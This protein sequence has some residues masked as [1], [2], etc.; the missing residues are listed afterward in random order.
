M[1]HRI[2]SIILLTLI[3]GL[4]V[5]SPVLAYIYRATYTV[6]ENASVPYDMVGVQTDNA[7]A[8]QWMADNG[9]FNSTANDTRIETLGGLEKPHMVTENLTYTAIPVPANSQTNLYFTTGNNEE[10]FDIIPGYDGYI[11]V[12]ND[13]DLEPGD[14]FTIEMKG[15]V[16]TDNWTDKNLVNKDNAI[17]VYISD[18]EEI[19]VDIT[20]APTDQSIRVS[21]DTDDIQRQWT[22]AAW[23]VNHAGNVNSAGYVGAANSKDGCGMRFN[24]VIL[25]QG[26]GIDS[27]N[28]T[29]TAINPEALND[30]NTKIS[31]ED[32]DNPITFS[33]EADFVARPQTTAFTYWDAMPAQLLNN[34]YVS[35][36]FAAVIQEIVDRPGWVS[37]NSIVIFWDDFDDRTTHTDGTERQEY[38]HNHTPAKAPLLSIGAFPPLAPDVTA[39]GIS[40]GPHT[41]EVSANITHLWIDVDGGAVDNITALGGGVPSN[42]ANWTLMGNNVMPYMEYYKHSVDGVLIAWYEPNAIIAG[43]A[44]PDRQG[45]DEPGIFSWGS[46]P[47]GVSVAIGGLV[48]SSQPSPGLALEGA[49]PDIMPGVEVTDWYIEPD[50]GVGGALEDNPLRPFVTILSGTTTLTELQ[51]WRILGS[52]FVLMVLTSAMWAVRGH[53][54]IA[55]IAT[56]A[57]ILIMVVWTI[58]PM[59]A[60]IVMAFAVV[61]G[62]ISERTHSL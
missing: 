26:Q 14:N 15:W 2:I 48:S 20:G 31:G 49:T 12:A 17:S 6:T 5:V 60:L 8:N 30:V 3:A 1:K 54:L 36:D 10:A 16:Y 18:N 57:A 47:T 52:A 32:A 62:L 43:T 45:G 22:G 11:T 9:Y 28:L 38:S 37:G 59:W 61:A 40:S 23:Q 44:L 46:N 50:V 21:A 25:A 51:A 41:I 33:D 55:G 13:P 58:Y 27:A 53:Y 29:F 34:E 35:P 7:V 19:S 4:L 56:G 24:N 39:F 42:S